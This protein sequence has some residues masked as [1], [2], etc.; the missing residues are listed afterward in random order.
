MIFCDNCDGEALATLTYNTQQ[1]SLQSCVV[2]LQFMAE[3]KRDFMED[4]AAATG[5]TFV[6]ELKGVKLQ[7]VGLS[8][9]GQ[10]AKVVVSKDETV[11]IGGKR[12]EE[13][14]NR[15]ITDIKAQ[16]ENEVD[17]NKKEQLKKRISRLTG[18]AA[19]LSIGGVTEVEMKERYDRADDAVRATA[20]AVEEGYVPGGGTAFLRID[21]TGSNIVNS[22]LT[23]PLKQICENSAVDYES[24]F[25]KLV[26]AG[27]NVGYNAKTGVVEDLVKSGIIEPTKSNR[28]ALQNA[29]SVVCAILT[30]KFTITDTL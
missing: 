2:E 19:T 21:D 9:F 16:E 26:D 25:D 20:S 6:N 8:A 3:K 27:Q 5:G 14:F 4:I 15:L 11:I 24:I 30:S 1:G 10:A 28:G 7:N 12:E 23:A 18:A 29:A 17:T 13:D 22:I